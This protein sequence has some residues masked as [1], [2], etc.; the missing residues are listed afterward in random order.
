MAL[1]LACLSC[2]LHKAR[3]DAPPPVAL[4]E[5]FAETEDG[6]P[7]PLYW[8]KAFG[9][10]ELDRLQEKALNANLDLRQAWARLAQADAL[11]RQAAAAQWPELGLSAGVGRSRTA[12]AGGR[13]G[14]A[15]EVDRV[16][17]SGGAAYE[18]DVWKR[19]ASLKRGAALDR[20]AAR[21]DLDA[22]AVTLSAR[23][24][25]TWFTFLEE[26]AQLDLLR[27]QEEMGRTF[28]ELTL[29]RFSTGLSSVLDVYQQRQ[30]LAAT[31][32]QIPLARARREVARHQLAVL[33]GEAVLP[34]QGLEPGRL[35]DLPPFPAVGVPADLLQRRPDIRRAQLRL[36][37]ADHR[38]AAALAD[39]LPALRIGGDTGFESYDFGEIGNLFSNWVWNVMANLTFPVFD[40]G[41][42]KAEVDRTRAVVRERLD[43]YGQAVLVAVQEVQDAR[44][45]EQR[46]REYLE[47]VERQV[48]LARSTLQEARVRYANGLSD[49]L[50]VLASLQSLQELERGLLAARRNL[51]A[52]R[53]DL[54]RA[55]GGDW[56]SERTD[57]AAASPDR[58]RE[59]SEELPR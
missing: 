27:E 59:E 38:I 31:R 29:L 32:A 51:L 35:A 19:V 2:A 30:Q 43:A 26:G 39:R 42:R 16:S 7:T 57:P 18:L 54:Y 55:M 8:W 1:L 33:V 13:L 25:T 46:H 9:D 12:V 17:L 53:V 3:E 24:A 44:V 50:P 48:A 21:Q 58:S 22:M 11:A 34:D 5:R 45:R 52:Y 40:G 6:E 20:D 36:A 28:L 23:V 4:P 56:P 41:R 15:V 37:A 47:G 14:G 10:P 49:Y